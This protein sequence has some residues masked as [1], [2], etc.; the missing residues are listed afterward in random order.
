MFIH[1][2]MLIIN[3]L[4]KLRIFLRQKMVIKISLYIKRISHIAKKS[5]RIRYY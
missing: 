5:S 4:L 2:K 1:T 3:N